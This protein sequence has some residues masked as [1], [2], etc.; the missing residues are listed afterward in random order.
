ML[1]GQKSVHPFHAISCILTNS[2]IDDN[3]AKALAQIRPQP[4]ESAH[5]REFRDAQV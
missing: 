4:F 2:R 1:Q 3:K 5:V